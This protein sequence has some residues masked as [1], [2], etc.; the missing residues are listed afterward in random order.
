M[1]NDLALQHEFLTVH[2]RKVEGHDERGQT[3]LLRGA[4]P[5]VQTAHGKT[6]GLPVPT[7][8]E[9]HVHSEWQEDADIRVQDAHAATAQRHATAMVRRRGRGPV[10]RRSRRGRHQLQVSA[11][12]V[13]VA[14]GRD[15]FAGQLAAVRR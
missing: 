5:A 8:A 4:V 7:S 2:R 11:R 13:D 10:R 1:Y 9:A 15:V 6:P 12:R 3:A 14:A